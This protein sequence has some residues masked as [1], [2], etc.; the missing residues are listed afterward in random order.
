M[1]TFSGSGHA[2]FLFTTCPA[3]LKAR[4]DG[5]EVAGMQRYF[6]ANCGN[7]FHTR[8]LFTILDSISKAS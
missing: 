3:T 2:L 6:L 7:C 1:F 4:S 8:G 5:T